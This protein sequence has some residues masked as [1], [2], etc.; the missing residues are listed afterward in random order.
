MV[1]EWVGRKV[2]GYCTI[3]KDYNFVADFRQ[4]ATADT[5]I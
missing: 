2:Y 1:P 4:A 3:P 5:S